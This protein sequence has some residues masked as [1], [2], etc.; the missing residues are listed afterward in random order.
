MVRPAPRR[1]RRRALTRTG[2][3]GTRADKARRGGLGAQAQERHEPLERD[4][5]H[6]VAVEQPVDAAVR[7]HGHRNQVRGHVGDDLVD[8]VGPV[9][10]DAVGE[11]RA[12]PA[13][14][15]GARDRVDRG[16]GSSACRR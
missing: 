7:L 14:S 10:A 8:R 9:V 15:G 1:V 3:S 5:V 16:G 13:G 12:D 4:R 6:E 11:R 2:E